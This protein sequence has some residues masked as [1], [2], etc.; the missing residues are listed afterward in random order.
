MRS[1]H[2]A[3]PETTNAGADPPDFRGRLI[4]VEEYE[5]T[6]SI[7]HCRGSGDGM[8]TKVDR[9]QHEKPQTVIAVRINWQPARDRLGRMGWREARSTE[10]AG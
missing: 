8:Q 3:G 9:K 2:R 4:P 5:R 1:K 7:G 10:E 6:D